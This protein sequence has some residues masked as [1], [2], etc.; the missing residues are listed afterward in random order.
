MFYSFL[1]R[2]L[3]KRQQQKSPLGYDCEFDIAVLGASRVGKTSILNRI[4]K[5]V[6]AAE[7]TPTTIETQ[8]HAV[9]L[10]S[11][12]ANFRFHDISCSTEYKLTTRRTI[13]SADA[14]VLVFSMVDKHSFDELE[15]IKLKIEV[16]KR[17]RISDLPV[18][19]IGNKIDIGR[20]ED[21]NDDI[22]KY[23]QNDLDSVFLEC[24][25][26]NEKDLSYICQIIYDELGVCG[27]LYKKVLAIQYKEERNE[28]EERHRLASSVK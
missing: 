23:C 12:K 19:V 16:L 6:F 5:H 14:F 3:E 8:E 21:A 24:S 11:V 18:I 25:A 13:L 2:K 22:L 27:S 4:T 15:Q 20:M 17:A 10:D 28:V 26:K 9:T 1:K 7:H